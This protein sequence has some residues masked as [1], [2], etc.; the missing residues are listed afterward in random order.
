[1]HGSSCDRSTV[2]LVVMETPGVASPDH[3]TFIWSLSD[4]RFCGDQSSITP[5]NRN[6]IVLHFRDG[7]SSELVVIKLLLER[8]C[9]LRV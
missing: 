2:T 5:P 3:K 8:L 1:M 9:R 4:R 7:S 6:N